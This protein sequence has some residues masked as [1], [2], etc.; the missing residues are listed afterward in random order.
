[1][2]NT[3][4]NQGQQLA[5][6]G[7][8]Q[9][10]FDKQNEVC[11][12]GPGGV[13]KT[14]LMG[15]LIDE[16]MPRYHQTCG[17]MGIKTEYHEVEMTATTNKAAEV[18]G[19]V[20][21]RPA[22]TIQSFLNLK[23]VDDYRT[24][25]SRLEKT[26][27]WKIHHNKIIFIDEASM[28]DNH[29]LTH[30]RE[31]T[32]NCK[33]IYVG[34]HC[35]LSPIK[36][37]ISPIYRQGIPFFELLEPM[38]NSKQPALVN[39]CN[40]IRRTVETGEF[41]P[42]KTHPGVI[43]HFDNEQMEAFCAQTFKTDSHNTRILAY[44]NQRVNQFNEHIKSLKQ[45]YD[46]YTEGEILINNSAIQLPAGM[47]SVEEEVEIVRLSCAVQPCEVEPGVTFSV[48]PASIKTS[49]GAYHTDV[50]LPMDKSHFNA[51][52][53]HY[54]KQK[55]WNRY[56]FL[57]NNFPDLRPRD[58]STIHKSQGSTYD[59]VIIDLGNL[60]TCH[61][62]NQAARLLYVAVSRARHR[63]ILFGQLTEKYGGVIS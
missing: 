2:T 43:D 59:T 60:S 34:D 4:L 48:V 21:G 10:L 15:H 47:L 18:L 17:L 6:D 49:H 44:S 22:Q 19:I 7:F 3:Y 28:I 9:F 32:H 55:N 25:E 5:S 12:S 50:L 36:E 33:I 46:S 20:T 8:F 63:I 41:Y 45:H 11:I 35:Q 62:A 16:I 40:Q 27:N 30:I 38:R 56:F 1:M 61:N 31:G 57:K 29:L 14:F 13:G 42:I 53:K 24:G 58:A 26:R 37:P 23:V 54:Q 39:L 51:L 52:V